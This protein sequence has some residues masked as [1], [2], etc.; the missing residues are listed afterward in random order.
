MSRLDDE[1]KNPAKAFL[2]WDGTNGGFNYLFIF[3]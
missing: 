1:V 2:Q 3:V